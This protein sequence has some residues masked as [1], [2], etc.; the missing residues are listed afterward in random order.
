MQKWKKQFARRE[1]NKCQKKCI[2]AYLHTFLRKF[3]RLTFGCEKNTTNFN[4]S[5]YA[6]LC[7]FLKFFPQE[8]MRT[9]H[10]FALFL[11]LIDPLQQRHVQFFAGLSKQWNIYCFKE[12]S[13]K[14][15]TWKY[16]KTDQIASISLKYLLFCCTTNRRGFKKVIK[17]RDF[18]IIL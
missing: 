16:W 9:C 2:F 7:F 6:A 11:T 14:T 3:L 15:A 5:W 4:L 10:H 8:I 17:N 1:T 12:L 13:T 18:C